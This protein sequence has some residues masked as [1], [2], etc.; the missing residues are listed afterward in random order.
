MATM[1]KFTSIDTA[2]LAANPT[3][4]LVY[5]AAKFGAN[6]TPVK[7]RSESNTW[8]FI[9]KRMSTTG[10]DSYFTTDGDFKTDYQKE[11]NKQVE[12]LKAEIEAHPEQT[13]LITRVGSGLANRHK[14]WEKVIKPQLPAALGHLPNVVFLWE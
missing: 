2:Y 4:I 14:I 6:N 11:F 5:G 3:H 1:A 12:M 8:A 13:Y 10:P 9:T 7:L